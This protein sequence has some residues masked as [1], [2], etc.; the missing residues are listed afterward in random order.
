MTTQPS[1]EG[2]DRAS[3]HPGSGGVDTDGDSNAE[4][5]SSIDIDVANR[6]STVVRQEWPTLVAT[7]LAD[8][9][10][11]T[12]AEDA[13][14]EAAEIALTRWANDQIPE[15]PGA[16]ITTVARRRAL[17]KLRREKIG[18]H[19][20]ELAARL[21]DRLQPH[22]PD[23]AETAELA[24]HRGR[25]GTNPERGSEK[26]GAKMRDEQ[27]KLVF[28]CCHPALSQEAQ[29]AL[30]LRSIGGLTTT[31]IATAFV[32]PEATMAQR[33]VR[34]K[35]KIS[36]AAIPF[37]IPDDAELLGRVAIVHQVLYLIFNEGYGASTGDDMVRVELSTEAIRL[38]RLL[39]KLMVD[40]AE[41]LGLLALMLLTD[42]RRPARV[43]PDGDL[44]LLA[45]QDR[46]L[47]LQPQ[48]DEGVAILH[49]ALRL[50][51][52]GGHQIEAAIAALHNEAATADDTDWPQIAAL[53]GRLHQL[54]PTPVVA[55][56]QAV[57]LAM[58]DGPDVGLAR[59]D[60]LAEPLANYRY[61]HAARADLAR[62]A[63]RIDEA[64]A[65]YS[66]ALELTSG[67]PERRFLKRRLAEL[68]QADQTNEAN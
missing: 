40:D 54:R 48:I 11:L 22:G 18:R 25:P 35:R 65:A 44:I 58:A 50:E 36:A 47:W 37:V 29:V 8:F 23:G 32:V 21:E 19:K 34:A 49:Q 64:R 26:S 63:E 41:T 59:L 14:Q 15:R 28:G 55:L 12:I 46:N 45:D 53:Y 4:P 31:E 30:T 33:L 5:G 38:T 10:D 24:D 20:L 7:L 66:R 51:R 62:R 68:P 67:S 56:N 6:I 57:A 61:F 9:G 60:P 42:A 17:D 1:A 43:G 39:A 2:H 52:P 27:L 3:T 16:W 13:A